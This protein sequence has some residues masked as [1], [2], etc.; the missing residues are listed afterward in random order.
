MA[1]TLRRETPVKNQDVQRWDPFREMQSL[2]RFDPFRE[3]RPFFGNFAS[4]EITFNPAFEVKETK[5]AFIF[6]AD[7]PGVKESDLDVSITGD[8]LLI[9]GKREEEKK[10]ENETLYTWER[11]Y[12]SFTRSFMLPQGIDQEHI[13]AELKEGVLT[14]VL[15]KLAEAQPR[16]IA[17]KSEKVKA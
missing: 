9:S 15:P 17:V 12:G 11:T 1:I 14:L 7:I 2:L 3:M 5:D 13:R 4:P 6:K 16:K 10:E 8:R